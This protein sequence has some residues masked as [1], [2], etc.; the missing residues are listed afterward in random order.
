MRPLFGR[1]LCRRAAELGPCSVE[2]N[3]YAAS[4]T[5]Q[6]PGK[7]LLPRRFVG[8]IS[9]HDVIPGFRTAGHLAH[10]LQIFFRSAQQNHLCAGFM[11]G[12]RLCVTQ[13]GLPGRACYDGLLSR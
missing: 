10:M 12:L 11:Q 7:S 2:Q 9:V 1:K 3:V 4:Q 13:S 5:L 6:R 8:Q